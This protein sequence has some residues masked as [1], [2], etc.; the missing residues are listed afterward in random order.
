MR[1]YTVLDRQNNVMYDCATVIGFTNLTD[2]QV[3]TKNMLVRNEA[4]QIIRIIN[5]GCF[6]IV[7]L[8][9]A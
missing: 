7:S 4:G 9:N 1:Y 6:D 3:L 8:F 2:E 5:R